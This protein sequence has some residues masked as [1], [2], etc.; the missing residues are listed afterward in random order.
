MECQICYEILET[1]INLCITECRHHF[2]S[3]CIFTW[4]RK[5]QSCPVCRKKLLSPNHVRQEINTTQSLLSVLILHQNNFIQFLKEHVISQSFMSIHFI[6]QKLLQEY[7]YFE[8]KKSSYWKQNI[9]NLFHKNK[10]I[11]LKM[12]IEHLQYCSKNELE[13]DSHP[14]AVFDKICDLEGIGT[15]FEVFFHIFLECLYLYNLKNNN[16]KIDFSNIISEH[17]KF[18]CE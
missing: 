9:Q 7:T 13:H 10:N 16:D 3:Q 17:G 1:T 2:C 12:N 15:D 6:Y 14:S 11:L 4:I 8:K 5:N 18:I